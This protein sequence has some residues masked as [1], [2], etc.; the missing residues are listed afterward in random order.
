[1]RSSETTNASVRVRICKCFRLSLGRVK[2]AANESTENDLL[3]ERERERV[4]LS[5]FVHDWPTSLSFW[6]GCLSSALSVQDFA[7]GPKARAMSVSL[8]FLRLYSMQSCLGNSNCTLG[9][10]VRILPTAG[11]PMPALDRC[12]SSKRAPYALHA[13]SIMSYQCGLTNLSSASSTSN[14]STNRLEQ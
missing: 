12:S 2:K 14:F 13:F 10:A 11:Q 6:S 5:K 3:R 8:Y 1:M 9:H 4:T 7:S